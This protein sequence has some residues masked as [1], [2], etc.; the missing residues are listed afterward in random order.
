MKKKIVREAVVL[1]Y[2]PSRGV[3]QVVAQGKG[4]VAERILAIAEENKIPVHEDP[5][6]AHVLNM[7]NIGDDIP[8]EL[9]HVVAQILIYVA[10]IDKRLR[11]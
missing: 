4:Y 3:P 9:Y 11:G 10:E 1:E 6:L 7:L 5:E 2:D 8:P